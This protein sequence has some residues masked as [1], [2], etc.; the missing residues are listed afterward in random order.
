MG[1]YLLLIPGIIGAAFFGGMP[2]YARMY[3]RPFFFDNL[4]KGEFFKFRHY[5]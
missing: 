5:F 1:L 2:F 4:P 3:R